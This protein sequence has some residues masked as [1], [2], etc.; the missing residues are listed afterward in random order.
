MVEIRD[1]LYF[2]MVIFL[3]PTLSREKI[4]LLEILKDE[5]KEITQNVIT[6]LGRDFVDL[7]LFNG[8]DNARVLFEHYSTKVSKEAVALT[9]ASF[10]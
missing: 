7:G 3:F 6:E 8:D 5:T 1:F 2:S 10:I 9:C 4:M